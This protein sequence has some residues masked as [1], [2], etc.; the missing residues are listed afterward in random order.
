M[1]CLTQNKNNPVKENEVINSDVLTMAEEG[2]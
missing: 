1:I 2:D